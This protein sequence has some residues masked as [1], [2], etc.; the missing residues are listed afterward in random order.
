MPRLKEDSVRFD[1]SVVDI[2]C[3]DPDRSA[4]PQV[5]SL[6]AV[7]PVAFLMANVVHGGFDGTSRPLEA[8]EM[9]TLHWYY[10]AS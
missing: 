2:F 1:G 9:T 3:Q 6:A 7:V 8:I 10:I 4:P 5:F